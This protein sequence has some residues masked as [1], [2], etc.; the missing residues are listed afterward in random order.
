MGGYEALSTLVTYLDFPQNVAAGLRMMFP[1]D[2]C[3]DAPPAIMATIQHVLRRVDIR[4]ITIATPPPFART[5]DFLTR[6][7][8]LQGSLEITVYDPLAES[9]FLITPSLVRVGYCFPMG[10]KLRG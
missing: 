4:C 6:F 5:E 8:G 10:L 3:V 7:E 1:E 2:V 9:E